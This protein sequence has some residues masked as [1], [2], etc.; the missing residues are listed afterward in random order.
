MIIP[1]LTFF[2]GIRYYFGFTSSFLLI[3]IKKVIS[4]HLKTDS[5]IFNPYLAFRTLWVISLYNFKYIDNQFLKRSLY[6]LPFIFLQI[7]IS[8]DIFR[9]LFIAFPI[10]IP[11]SLY[12]FKIKDS[13]IILIFL[14]LSIFTFLFY[15]FEV[16]E[17][18]GLLVSLP[19]EILI[20]G[21]LII[22]SY[23]LK[24]SKTRSIQNKFSH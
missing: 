22:Y 11:L 23:S 3:T 7:F 13:K 2:I 20:S 10:I 5:I 1:A 15:L 18:R 24:N 9:A 8:T 19:L 14:L 16:K 21:T 17:D 12:L 4:H 6:V